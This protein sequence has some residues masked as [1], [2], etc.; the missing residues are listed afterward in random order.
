ME[1]PAQANSGC[2]EAVTGKTLGI[3]FLALRYCYS[4][5]KALSHMRRILSTAK[6]L[7]GFKAY[8]NLLTNMYVYAHRI[9]YTNANSSFTAKRC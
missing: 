5:F 3:S 4:P 7:Y 9:A 8:D 1:N 6:T 2:N